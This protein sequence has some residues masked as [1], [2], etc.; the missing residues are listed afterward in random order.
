MSEELNNAEL[1][2]FET[3]LARLVPNAPTALRDRVVF[4][5]GQRSGK[6]QSVRYGVLGL[7]LGLVIAS[8]ASLTLGRML[9]SPQNLNLVQAPVKQKIMPTEEGHEEFS[10]DLASALEAQARYF[11]LQEDLATR[12]LD[13]LPQ[14]A[15]IEKPR[16]DSVGRLLESL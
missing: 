6:K 9:R 8:T 14:P 5:A 16:P 12:G 1:T 2:D 11:R 4:R 15:D 3:S 7:A 10:P 13:A